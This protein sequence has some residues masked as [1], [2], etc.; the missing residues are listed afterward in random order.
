MCVTIKDQLL[1]IGSQNKYFS[2]VLCQL[3]DVIVNVVV[4]E[5]Y[6]VHVVDGN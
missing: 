5:T 2:S 6:V 3:V 1:D 4:V